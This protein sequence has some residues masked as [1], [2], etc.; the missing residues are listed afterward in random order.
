MKWPQRWVDLWVKTKWLEWQ[1]QRATQAAQ[2]TPD[3]WRI[4]W[5]APNSFSEGLFSRGRS[6]SIDFCPGHAMPAVRRSNQGKSPSLLYQKTSLATNL[7]PRFGWSLPG[8][9]L[10]E[11]LWLWDTACSAAGR[12][13]C[14][15][16]PASWQ[17]AALGRILP[18]ELQ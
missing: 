4:L 18:N 6:I 13:S 3:F 8:L 15:C 10:P 1:S 2:W 5:G 14:S 9:S 7:C 17:H 12:F 16:D 11:Q